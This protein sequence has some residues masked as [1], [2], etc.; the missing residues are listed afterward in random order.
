[1][2]VV[3][4]MTTP[5]P[6]IQVPEAEIESGTTSETL[7]VPGYAAGRFE[8]ATAL[9]APLF[10]CPAL[11]GEI[12]GDQPSVEPEPDSKSQLPQLGRPAAPGQ[13][14]VGPLQVFAQV[15]LLQIALALACRQS[16]QGPPSAP[17]CWAS[18][19]P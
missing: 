18:V 17:Q 12:M 4:Q 9:V 5:T 11:I 14:S 16:M 1:M 19:S 6:P 3:G 7:P 2:A 13:D 8:L 15:P 10:G